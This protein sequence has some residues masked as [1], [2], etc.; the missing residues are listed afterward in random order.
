MNFDKY[1]IHI[2]HESGLQKFHEFRIE[3]L[4]LYLVRSSEIMVALPRV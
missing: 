2:Y 3:L 4:T 1:H